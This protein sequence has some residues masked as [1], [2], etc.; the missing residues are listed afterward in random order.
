LDA[1]V[2]PGGNPLTNDNDNLRNLNQFIG[3]K[4][5]RKTNKKRW[6]GKRKKTGKRMK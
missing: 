3:G 6:T 2:T 5:R 4:R 1:L